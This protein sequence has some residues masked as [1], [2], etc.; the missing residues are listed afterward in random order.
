MS[1]MLIFPTRAMEQPYHT[2]C[3]CV[4][5]FMMCMYVCGRP[6]VYQTAHHLSLISLWFTITFKSCPCLKVCVVSCVRHDLSASVALCVCVCVFTRVCCCILACA[7]T[8]SW[9]CLI[10]QSLHPEATTAKALKNHNSQLAFTAVTFHQ[11][12]PER[13]W[14]WG[15][16][17]QPQ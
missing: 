11:W 12:L 2:L 3:V 10:A 7:C 14:P 1:R 4:C 9:A 13:R 15:G 8:C 6:S 17:R 5:V 16:V